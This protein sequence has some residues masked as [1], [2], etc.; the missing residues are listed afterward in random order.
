[1][2]CRLACEEYSKGLGHG[3]LESAVNDKISVFILSRV[4]ILLLLLGSWQVCAH[5]LGL[6]LCRFGQ[7]FPQIAPFT[8]IGKLFQKKLSLPEQVGNV[9][10]ITFN[11]CL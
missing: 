6:V 10:Y 9:K 1:M 3:P 4:F 8:R 5:I 2:L 11:I 7:P